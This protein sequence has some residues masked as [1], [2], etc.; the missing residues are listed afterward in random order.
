MY[1]NKFA[2]PSFA[3]MTA[4]LP[5]N[6]GEPSNTTSFTDDICALIS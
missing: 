3:F 5:D 6:Y 2:S 4:I 1:L